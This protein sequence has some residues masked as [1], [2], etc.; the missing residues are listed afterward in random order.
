[1]VAQF[2]ADLRPLGPANFL[3]ADAEVLFAHGNRCIHPVSGWIEPP[4]LFRLAQSSST[5]E[6]RRPG[7]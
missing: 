5:V 7:S 2:A 4:G 3:Y 1:M 6:Q